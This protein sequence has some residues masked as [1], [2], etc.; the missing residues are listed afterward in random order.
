MKADSKIDA[1]GVAKQDANG[2]KTDGNSRVDQ[3]GDR[4]IRGDK[5]LRGDKSAKGE[6]KQTEK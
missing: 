4:S 6:A 1:N 3:K 2:T 5:S